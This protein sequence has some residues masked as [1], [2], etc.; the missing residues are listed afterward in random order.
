M[1]EFISGKL[2]TLARQLEPFV[3]Q[4]TRDILGEQTGGRGDD[5]TWIQGTGFPKNDE[6]EMRGQ[7]SLLP[8]TTVGGQGTGYVDFQLNRDNDDEVTLGNDATILGGYGNRTQWQA[9]ATIGGRG[10]HVSGDICWAMGNKFVVTGDGQTDWI[11]TFG[12][13][14]Y[15]PEEYFDDPEHWGPLYDYEL[16]DMGTKHTML[17]HS[18]LV[19][20]DIIHGNAGG[21]LCWHFEIDAV[22]TYS[23]FAILWQQTRTVYSDGLGVDVRIGTEYGLVWTARADYYM[24][25][26]WFVSTRMVEIDF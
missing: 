26:N 24:G 21:N 13:E 14:Y 22:C 4:W 11:C 1:K 2:S 19:G 8:S 16:Y 17:I 15:Y 18:V 5:L 25:I 12:E 6:E 20:H 9:D 23:P 7:K 10:A 3:R